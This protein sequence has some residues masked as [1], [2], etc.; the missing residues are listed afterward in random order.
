MTR[1]FQD[2]GATHVTPWGVMQNFPHYGRMQA[3][4]WLRPTPF[5][6]FQQHIEWRAEN[7]GEIPTGDDGW[8]GRWSALPRNAEPLR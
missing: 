7:G 8:I 3:R 4:Y 6:T 2:E 1:R 5:N